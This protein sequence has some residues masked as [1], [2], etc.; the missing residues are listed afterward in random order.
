MYHSVDKSCQTVYLNQ[1]LWNY[2]VSYYNPRP[3]CIEDK[4]KCGGDIRPDFTDTT[5]KFKE[6]RYI[7][8]SMVEEKYIKTSDG[9]SLRTWYVAGKVGK[10]AVIVVH[11]H[12]CCMGRWETA[13]KMNALAQAG[14]AT[15]NKLLLCIYVLKNIHTNASQLMKHALLLLSLQFYSHGNG[16]KKPRLF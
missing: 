3:A 2:D 5:R 14:Y 13:N 8:E 11:G 9:L 1:K 6:I 7:N 12:L 4:S 10:P 15:L 16:L